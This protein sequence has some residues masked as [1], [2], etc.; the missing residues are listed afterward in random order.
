MTAQRGRT[1]REVEDMIDSDRKIIE[2]EI[3]RLEKL[4]A[5][6]QERYGI[7]GSRSTDRTM[8]RY[9]VIQEALERTL[10]DSRYDTLERSRMQLLNT[11][12]EVKR[13][14]VT[15]AQAGRIPADVANVITRIL[16]E[17]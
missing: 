10:N 5:D 17:V 7:T 13:M 14:I 6:A 15:L 8:T 3:E 12:T 11:L 16:T 2:A 1:E 9:R 4:W